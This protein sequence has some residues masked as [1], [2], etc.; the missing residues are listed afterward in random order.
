MTPP[1]DAQLPDFQPSAAQATI[2]EALLIELLVGNGEACKYYEAEDDT[3]A[4]PIH[5][6]LHREY[7]VG[8][9]RVHER[10]QDTAGEDA[11]RAR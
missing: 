1:A 2:L 4:K 10:D 5:G 3:G 8:D 7:G 6:L 9:T 11:R